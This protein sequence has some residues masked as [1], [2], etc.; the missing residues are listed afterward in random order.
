MA[1]RFFGLE[2]LPKNY[3]LFFL[4]PDKSSIKGQGVPGTASSFADRFT[5]FL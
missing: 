4:A 2:N 5:A 1:D 3:I